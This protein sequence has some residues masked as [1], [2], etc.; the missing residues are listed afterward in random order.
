MK[1]RNRSAK[2]PWMNPSDALAELAALDASQPIRPLKTR[3]RSREDLGVAD[4]HEQTVR[5]IITAASLKAL[6]L[7]ARAARKATLRATASKAGMAHTQLLSIE[8]SDGNVQ[9]TTLSRIAAALDC[10]L[11]VAFVPKDNAPV[12]ET[13]ILG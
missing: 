6:L 5:E 9:L 4:Q 8:N 7:E 11:R 1:K 13:R 3:N 10:E 12:L 2:Q